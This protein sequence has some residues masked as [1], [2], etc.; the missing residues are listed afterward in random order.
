VLV[1]AG[2]DGEALPTATPN[3]AIAF[4]AGDAERRLRFGDVVIGIG[5]GLT[6]STVVVD[7]EDGG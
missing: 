2:D 6:S 1:D 7:C 5:R 3:H 4:A